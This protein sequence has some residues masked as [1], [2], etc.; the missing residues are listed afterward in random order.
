MRQKKKKDGNWYISHLANGINPKTPRADSS[1]FHEFQRQKRT[2]FSL[3]FYQAALHLVRIQ[4]TAAEGI[5]TLPEAPTTVT[6]SCGGPSD[7]HGHR[8]VGQD[9][10][11]LREDDREA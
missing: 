10:P 2:G 8:A 11:R 1:G 5:Q 7:T 3:K 4:P 9:Q 6:S